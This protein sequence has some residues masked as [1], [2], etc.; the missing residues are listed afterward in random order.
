M[1]K[2]ENKKKSK[3]KKQKNLAKKGTLFPFSFFSRD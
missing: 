3:N 1:R 2:K